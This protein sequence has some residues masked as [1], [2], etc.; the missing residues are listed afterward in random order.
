M[1][2]ACRTYEKLR[3]AYKILVKTLKQNNQ[4]EGVVQMGG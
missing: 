2:E 1:G 4:I 3:N